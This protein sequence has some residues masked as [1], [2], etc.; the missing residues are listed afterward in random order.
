MKKL[1]FIFFISIS[2]FSQ[3]KSF[4]QRADS[5]LA[6][7]TLEEKVGQLVQYSGGWATGVETGKPTEGSDELIRKGKVGSFLNVV[8][9]KLTGKMQK[10][11]AEE[12][13]L[14]IPLIFG[15]DVIHGYVSTFP[16]PL[17]EASSWNPSLVEKSARM[18][19]L[20]A[21]S[22]GIHWTFNPMVDIARDPR[23]GRIMEGSG[24]DPYLGSQMAAARVRGYQG[25]DLSAN[26][27]ILA[28]VKHY[29][30][31]GGA[32]GGRDY[33][34]V[35]LSER[36][37]RDFYL[38]P[39]KAGV[40][41]GAGSLMASFN[42]IGGVPSS[43][44]KFLMTQ[45]LRNEWKTDA[46]VVS[47]WNSIGELIPH[48]V[49]K[50]LKEAAKLGIESTVDMDMEAN[51]YYS[52]LANLVREG[53]ID[54]K[55]VDAAVRRVLI[56]KFKLGL[57]DDPFKYCNEER[58]QKTIKSKEIVD[59]TKEVALESIVLLKNEKNLLPL[60]KK[61]K[62]IAVVG[63]LA[64][65]I[66]DPLGGWSALGDSN[67]VVSIFDGIKNKIGKDVKIN[68]AKGCKITGNDKSGF[69]E[70]INVAKLSDV[71][72]AVVGETRNMSGEAS[73]RATLDLPGVQEDLLKELYKIGKPIVVIL[74]N[75]RPLTIPWL[76]ENIPAI[77][78]AWYPGISAGSVVADIL[79]GDVNPSGK[80][81]VTFPRYVGQIPI[82]YN[83][84]NTGRPHDP[85]NHYT[86]YYMDLDNTPLYPF[87]FGLSY[88]T[89]EYSNLTLDK[90][91]IKKNESLKVFVDVKNTGTR[92]GKEV[93]QL[94]IRDLVGSVTR[95]VKELK[96]FK[97]ISLKPG[98][99]KH[100]E[101][102]ITPDKLKFYDINMD[103]VL[104]SGDFQVFVGTN[105]VDVKETSFQIVE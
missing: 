89:F 16:V 85:K 15:L 9:S 11:A 32:E 64:K 58:E 70:A 44:S 66:S 42:E 4:E 30:G 21:S 48:G 56:A 8:S 95:P 86:S 80:L 63:Y 40:E 14:K 39:Y 71:I 27:T 51:A 75:G 105:S 46:F 1:L 97:K 43:A 5:V 12:S 28:C 79:F 83:H 82:Y 103:Y 81:T 102:T 60:D 61:L 65:S 45:I 94:Y 23:W 49:A 67:D 25:N 101:F 74:M 96:D 35:D 6:L 78:E 77:V 31:Y 38:P 36:N 33:N 47:D 52:H 76:Q 53:K 59:A 92:E 50:D 17:A 84:K 34:T 2:I 69:N 13:R 68:Y 10:I 20:E 26:N 72:I 29:A 57:F 88:T 41:A 73:S 100:V 87:G 98:E 3:K 91:E 18:Q 22:A 19:A 37:F 54:I 90:K 55:L 99:T 24:E 93:V 62:S 7:M 104:E